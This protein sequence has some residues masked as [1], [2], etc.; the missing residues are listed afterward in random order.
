M[1]SLMARRP[2]FLT[3]E[4]PVQAGL[5]PI[6]SRNESG[7]LLAADEPDH[8]IWYDPGLSRDQRPD[9]AGQNQY[10]AD[11]IRSFEDARKSSQIMVCKPETY[12]VFGHAAVEASLVHRPSNCSQLAVVHNRQIAIRAGLPAEVTRCYLG[13]PVFHTARYWPVSPDLLKALSTEELSGPSDAFRAHFRLDRP[14]TGVHL[15]DPAADDAES[16]VRFEA[17]D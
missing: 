4:E 11:H 6:Q 10:G 14:A 17:F 16:P 3:L 5:P 13:Y 1:T 8:F 7:H 2:G 9:V 15:K 12:D